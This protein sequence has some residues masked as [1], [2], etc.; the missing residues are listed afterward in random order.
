MTDH[1]FEKYSLIS[2]VHVWWFSFVLM[3]KESLLN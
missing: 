3:L 2:K 1:L